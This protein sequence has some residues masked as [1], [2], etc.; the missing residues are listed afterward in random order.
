MADAARDR[1]HGGPRLRHHR[2]ARLHATASRRAPLDT[3]KLSLAGVRLGQ[4]GI[5]VILAVLAVTA[6]Y[7]TRTIQPTLAA[8]PHRFLVVLGKLGVLA[9][10]GWP[11]AS[12]RLPG[13][14]A[15]DRTMLPG[16]GFTRGT[17]LSGAVAGR[18]PAP[19]GRRRYGPLPGTDRRARGRGSG[20]CCGTPPVRSRHRARAAL[21]IAGGRHVHQRPD[22]GS[23]ASTGTPRWTPG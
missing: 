23:T 2:I 18:P 5:L 4:V 22:S 11:R 13:R 3:T 6:E 20:S 10:S 21:R 1:R 8:V 7:S 15:A 12:W 17:R 16:N 14:L 9:A 19:A